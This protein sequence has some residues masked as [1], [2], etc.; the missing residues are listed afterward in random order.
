MLRFLSLSAL[1]PLP[2][3]TSPLRLSLL[4]SSQVFDLVRGSIVCGT[5]EEMA[6][7]LQALQDCCEIRVVR[8][9]DRFSSPAPGSW[10][11]VMVNVIIVGDRSKHICEIQIVHSSLLAV[12][13]N[14]KGHDDYAVSRS[15]SELVDVEVAE[16][17]AA[18]AEAAKVE[19]KEA[20]AA[21]C[22]EYCTSSTLPFNLTFIVP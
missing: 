12:R 9:K 22:G 7:A 18:E 19:G 1:S 21:R 15:A 3:S 20:E 10:M 6:A 5:M 17:R 13:K 11:D 16:R 4:L 2:S 8:V 14:M